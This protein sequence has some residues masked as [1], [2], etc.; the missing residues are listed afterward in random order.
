MSEVRFYHLTRSPLEVT[1]PPLLQKSIDRGWRVLVHGGDA[2]RLKI[3]DER[4]WI[5]RPDSF[6]PHG[7]ASE[8]NASDQPILLSHS[9]E[10]L[11]NATVLMLVDGAQASAKYMATFDLTCV[12]F[13]GNDAK[14]LETARMDWKAVTAAHMQAVYWAQ[15]SAGHWVKKAESAASV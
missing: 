11:N 5:F 12:F 6:L 9:A 4:L 8:G 7:L 10:N 13:D 1:L 2:E 3:L 15:D 14:A